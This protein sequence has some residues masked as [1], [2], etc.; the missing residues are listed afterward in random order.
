[1]YS[2]SSELANSGRPLF[3]GTDVDDQLK[4]IFKILGT[5]SEETWPG[6]SQLPD[7]KP[8]PIYVPNS[9]LPQVS[10]LSRSFFEVAISIHVLNGI[11]L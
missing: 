10:D 6:V 1:M 9:N 2:I 8:F 4:K 5:P 3:P 11:I 7:Y